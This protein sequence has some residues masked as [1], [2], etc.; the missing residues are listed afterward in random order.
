MTYRV[1]PVAIGTTE[2]NEAAPSPAKVPQNS[3]F[4]LSTMLQGIELRCRLEK[5]N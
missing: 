2:H 5:C 1:A 4:A 3:M